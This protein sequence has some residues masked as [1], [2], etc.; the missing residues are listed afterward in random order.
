[1][2]NE[3][4]ENRVS[5]LEQARSEIEDT[6][7]VM[8]HLEARQSQILKDHTEWMERTEQS[9]RE[10]EEKLNALINYVMKRDGFPESGESK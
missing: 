6:L 1:M 4:L 9:R 5:K 2:E 3:P 10:A 7:L 8:A